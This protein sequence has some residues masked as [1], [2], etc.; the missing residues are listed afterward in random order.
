MR[1]KKPTILLFNEFIEPIDNTISELQVIGNNSNTQNENYILKGALVYST[2]LFESSIT[3]CL[4]K[5]LI[6]FPEKITEGN[7]TSKDLRYLSNAIYASDILEQMIDNLIHEYTY[8][9]MDEILSTSLK[10]LG[11][12][13]KDIKYNKSDLIEKKE[14]RNILVHNSLKIDKTYIFKTKCDPDLYREPLSISNS[15]IKE[16]LELFLDILGQIRNRLHELYGEYNRER[17]I[18]NVWNFIF[19]SPLLRY[20]DYWGK[21]YFNISGNKDK[22][23]CI[24][25]GEKTWLAYWIQHYCPANVDGYIKFGEMSYPAYHSEKMIFLSRFFDKYPHILQNA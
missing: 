6:A 1:N 24:S 5:Y 4:K 15:Y 2:S 10:V 21:G 13:I 25:S 12:N 8:K 11:I 19:Q 3:D 16:T 7:I 17:L 14:R 9:N 18:N 23:Q 22:I 20:D